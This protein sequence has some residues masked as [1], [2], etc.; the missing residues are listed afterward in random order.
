MTGQESPAADEYSTVL[1]RMPSKRSR[2]LRHRPV[3]WT[4]CLAVV[5][6]SLLT[7][8]VEGESDSL[9][10]ELPAQLQTVRGEFLVLSAAVPDQA[11]GSIA[12]G[13]ATNSQRAVKKLLPDLKILEGSP[14]TILDLTKVF[15]DDP[16]NGTAAADWT[17]ELI[18]T[19]SSVAEVTLDEEHR[20]L[21]SWQKAGEEDVAIRFRNLVS[22]EVIDTRFRVQ[23]WVPDWTKLAF[24]VIGGLGIF[25]FGM[26]NMSEGMQTVFGSGLRQMISLVTANRFL[27]VGIGAAVTMVVQSSSIT[28][29]MVVGFVNSGFMT[30]LQAVGVVMGANIG[31]TI[32]GWILVLKIGRFGLPLL[33]L[34]AFGFLFSRGDRI[35][36]LSSA[37]MGLGMIFFGL[38]LMK[39]GFGTIKDLP[40]FESWF[41]RFTADSYSNVLKCALAGCILTAIVQSS[42]ATLGITI[43]LAEIGVIPF[44]SAAALVI[45]ENLGT[46]VTAILAALGT[47]TNAR[48]TALFHVVFNAVGV[49]WITAIFVPIYCPLLKSLF[50]T[51]PDGLRKAIAFAHTG[52]NLTNTLLFIWFVP[53]VAHWLERIVPDRAVPSQSQLSNLDVRVLD[54]PLIAIEQSRLEVCRMASFCRDMTDLMRECIYDRRQHLDEKLVQEVFDREAVLDTMQ[55]EIVAYM[56]NLF[57][58]NVP[59]HIIDEGRRQLRIADEY[60]SVSDYLVTIVKSHLKLRRGSLEFGT[61]EM[62]ELASLH[63]AAS[64]Y[65][66]LV[67][68]GMEKKQ[69]DILPIAKSHGSRLISR[70]K[71]LRNQFLERMARDPYP[72]QASVAFTAQLNA[73]RRVHDHVLNVAEAVAGE[74]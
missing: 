47:N 55:D 63:Q 54:T 1:T 13:G 60:E 23:V 50:D 59:H 70:I 12:N 62:E 71:E 16:F 39:E 37:L 3:L 21:L 43:G 27:A 15:A 40:A 58:G 28:T 32:T 9:R 46:T 22:A 52:F 72:P 44:E 67:S 42:S 38:E 17:A 57:A 56:T 11:E 19:P 48:R 36:Y 18:E 69:A 6:A 26:K 49:L 20:L 45:G 25:L 33:G 2:V 51:S 74:K 73:Y 64:E 34:G 5:G 53:H 7:K 30:L 66:E 61:Q 35:R 31:T 14:D 24:T 8:H 10:E 68:Q 65:V 29:V 41:A 4:L